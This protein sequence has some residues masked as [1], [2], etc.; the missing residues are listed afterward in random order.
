MSNDNP[1]EMATAHQWL[2]SVAREFELDE[3][4]VRRLAGPLLDLTR[5]VAH[6]RSRPAA[7]LTAFLVGLAS[8]GRQDA[9]QVVMDVEK[10]VEALLARIAE[11]ENT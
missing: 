5:E 7:P 1:R 4:I 2:T 10:R 11:G 8:Q 3:E 9:D 6:Q